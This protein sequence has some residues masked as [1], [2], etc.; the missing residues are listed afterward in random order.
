MTGLAPTLI[1]PDLEA[2]LDRKGW[3]V[4]PLLS[5]DEVA[6]LRHHYED[7]ARSGLSPEG[8]HDPTYAEF[9][10]IHTR[11]DFRVEAFDRIT[12]VVG[13]RARPLLAGFRPLVANYVNKAPGTGIVPLHQNWAVVDEARFRS[14]SVWV[15]LVDATAGNGT[16]EML[17]GSHRAFRSPRGMWAFEAF[18]EVAPDL[19]DELEVVDVAAGHA[20]V[21]DDALLHY[22]APNASAQDRLAIQL[23]MVPEAAQARFYRRVGRDG[24][25]HVVEVWEVSEPFF[26]D[27]W[28]GDGD[29]RY[30]R[31]VEEIRMPDERVSTDELRAR[32]AAAG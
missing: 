21:L 30:G 4:V 16:L 26:F 9:S 29:E 5:P 24:D 11:P 10:V 19:A 17:P 32:V 2:E 13:E 1:D 6:S 22:S 28:H 20:I 31:V 14:V 27:F 7:A 3:V 18:T 15:P 8:A 12:A 23:V 25:D